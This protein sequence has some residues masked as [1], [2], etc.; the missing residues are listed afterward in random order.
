M[1]GFEAAFAVLAVAATATTAAVAIKQSQDQAKL[2]E[3][4]SE[5]K[6]KDAE[7]TRQN[8]AYEERNVRRKNALIISRQNAIFAAA[9]IDPMSGS[10]SVL[11]VD[12]AKEAEMEA[13]AVRSGGSQE[14]GA[15][16]FESR[17]A[18]YRSDSAR[19]MLG[20][21]VA[22][23]VLSTASAGMGAYYTAR[24]RRSVVSDW[25]N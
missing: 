3:T 8:A 24:G 10:P 14:S 22:G 1:T 19:G 5:Q 6:V 11:Q 2:D 23:G 7:T 4:I 18:K 12:S 17:I 15:R 20:Y 25:T 13:L 16:L 9:G 21:Q